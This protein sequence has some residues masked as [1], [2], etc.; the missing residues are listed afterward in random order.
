MKTNDLLRKGNT[1]SVLSMLIS[2]E[3]LEE[4]QCVVDTDTGMLRCYILSLACLSLCWI[5]PSVHTSWLSVCQVS[6]LS[7]RESREKS[8]PACSLS[9]FCKPARHPARRMEQ[10]TDEAAEPPAAQSCPTLCDP[11]DCSTPGS[12]VLH[13]LSELAQTPLSQWCHPTTSSCRPLLLLPSIFPS[14]KVFSSESALRIRWPQYW[15]FSFSI[16]PSN[17][18]SGL[19]SFTIDPWKVIR[20]IVHSLFLGLWLYP[21]PAYSI[22]T[23]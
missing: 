22:W 17:E 20:H 1:F 11:M 8:E 14:F 5:I 15:G 2:Q 18:F 13:H 16:S 9:P 19:V 7:T 10:G 21:W 23:R 12:L 4:K 6:V 3:V